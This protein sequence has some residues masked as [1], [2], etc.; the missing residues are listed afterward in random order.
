[1]ELLHRVKAIK[2]EPDRERVKIFKRVAVIRINFFEGVGWPELAWA[3]LG[4]PGLAWPSLGCPKWSP[5]SFWKLRVKIH[6]I[7]VLC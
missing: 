2:R 1:M 6:I 7:A 5:G 3:G 4:W